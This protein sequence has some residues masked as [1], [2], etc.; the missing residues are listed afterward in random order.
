MKELL[1]KLILEEIRTVLLLMKK[2]TPEQAV[3]AGLGLWISPPSNDKIYFV[4][5]AP[6]DKTE[7]TKRLM[8]ASRESMTEV[9]FAGQIVRSLKTVGHMEIKHN[10]RCNA[11]E[12]KLVSADK[13]YGPFLYDLAMNHVA[14]TPMMPD[15]KNISG[16]AS[17]IWNFYYRYREDVEKIHIN[18]PTCFYRKSGNIKDKYFKDFTT[19]ASEDSPLNFYYMVK[20]PDKNWYKPLY[21]N[22]QALLEYIKT[23][24]YK[25]KK[26]GKF[27]N[28]SEEFE[29]VFTGHIKFVVDK[30]FDAKFS[31]KYNTT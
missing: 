6:P 22:H 13:G 17:K 1:E 8:R 24:P 12:V 31:E 9:W 5:Y 3:S 4:L 26:Y 28:N 16:D 27:L 23:L 11:W 10:H 25:L 21:D 18:D 30:F 2:V 29:K 20:N 19:E 14:P 7:L 15:R